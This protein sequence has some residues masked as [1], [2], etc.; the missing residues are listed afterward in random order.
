MRPLQIFLS[1]LLAG[2]R[3]LS[4][5]GFT[6]LGS[7]F[8]LLAALLFSQPEWQANVELQLLTFLESHNFSRFGIE[9]DLDAVDRATAV[10]PN[11]LNRE[12]ARIATWL[13]HKYHVATEPISAL[14]TAAYAEGRQQKIEPSL[15][16]AVIAIES[17]FNPYAQSAV[18][19]QGLM[20]VMPNIHA[21]RYVAYGGALAAFDPLTNL[22]VGTAILRDC[23]KLKG[24][25]EDGLQYYAGGDASYATK[26][27]LEEKRITLVGQGLS[28]SD[29]N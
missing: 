27:L 1:D 29:G 14:V 15:I 13:S 10:E 26:V 19:A 12:Q 4:R 24:S 28:I 16:L 7:V 22:R 6:V 5:S 21:A 9:T 20:Q 11:S 3:A 8:A 25:V 2:F 17:N 23:L 18:G